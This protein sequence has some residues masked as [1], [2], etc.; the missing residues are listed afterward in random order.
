MDTNKDLCIFFCF[1]FSGVKKSRK[2]MRLFMDD[3]PDP[4]ILYDAGPSSSP[5]MIIKWFPNS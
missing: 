1:K 4:S 2:G 3:V 5:A